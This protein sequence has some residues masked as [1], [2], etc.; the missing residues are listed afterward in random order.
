MR[1]AAVQMC[2]GADPQR[3]VADAKRLVYEAAAAGAEYIQLPEYF[4]YLGPESGYPRS[5][6]T[7]SGPTVRSFQALAQELDAA[8]HLGSIIE[9]SETPA[10]FFNTSVL[11]DR[12]GA[13]RGIYRKVHLFDIEV[14]GEVEERESAT[15][16]PG[17]RLCIAA[18][19]P[20]EIGL[21]T[22]F[23]IRFPELYRQLLIGGATAFAVPAAF[24]RATGRVHWEVL[25]RARAIENHAFVI[26][27]AQ[28]G[29]TVE[30]IATHG[31]SLVVD[32]WGE[33]LAEGN[34]ESEDLLVMDLEVGDVAKRRAQI[35]IVGLRRPDVYAS[36][37]E[38]C[39]TVTTGSAHSPMMQSQ[40]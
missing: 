11:I 16:V 40:Q 39:D 26:A 17:S 29:E 36:P 13:L 32:P 3:N 27:A 33:I 1:V 28:A 34:A 23:D 37:V 2:S 31:H 15:I 9:P 19:G 8:I 4:V 20:L 35:D 5:A 21:S 30:G 38:R 22:C 12:S 10:R 25:V 7:L 6:E 24:A 14:P 18:L